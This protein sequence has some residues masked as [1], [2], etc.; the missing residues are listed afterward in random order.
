VRC[1]PQKVEYARPSAEHPFAM[2]GEVAVVFI[3]QGGDPFRRWPEMA[4]STRREPARV[5]GRTILGEG[6]EALVEGGVPHGGEKGPL[7]T[8]RRSASVSQA[9][10]RFVRS[11]E[12]VGV[13]NARDRA[14]PVPVIEQS[15]AEEVLARGGGGGEGG[16]GAGGTADE[17]VAALGGGLLH[18]GADDEA[19]RVSV[20][21]IARRSPPPARR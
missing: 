5:D 19:R 11:A 20:H 17:A 4:G 14:A 1:P 16:P 12:E 6:D 10:H 9:D 8:S 15:R 21:A 13:H 18:L 3:G 7:W 2:P